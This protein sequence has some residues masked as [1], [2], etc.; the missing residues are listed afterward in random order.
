MKTRT[1]VRHR[2]GRCCAVSQSA[3]AVAPTPDEMAAGP[4]M[5]RGK[6]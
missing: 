5:G 1:L 3:R 6:I 2:R 4:T